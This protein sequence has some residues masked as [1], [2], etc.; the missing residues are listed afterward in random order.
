VIKYIRKLLFKEDSIIEKREEI[1]AL[2]AQLEALKIAFAPVIFQV[3]RTM[4]EFGI[5]TLLD[6]RK[7]GLSLKEI[8][9]KTEISTYGAKILL[10]SALSASVVK[11]EEGKYT[12]TKIGYFLENDAMVE[13]NM[14]FNHDVNYKGLFDLDKSIK[15]ERPVGLQVFGDW[16]TIYPHLGILPEQVKKSWFDFDHFYSD[17]AFDSAIEKLKSFNPKK[18]LDIGGNTGKFSIRFAKKHKDINLTILDLPGQ[19]NMAQKNIRDNGLENNVDYFPLDIL[20]HTAKIP[21]GFDIIW[22]S[23]FIDC[24]S[25]EDA[26]KILTRVRESMNENARLCILEPLWD[27]QRFESASYCIINTS[28]YFTAMANGNS[29][30]FNSTDLFDYIQRAG[31]EIEETIANIG[32][33]S[34]TL[35]KCKNPLA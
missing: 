35:V 15:E 14:A 7:E 24:F 16:E 23:Q 13:V 20:N 22:M 32:V 2:D 12:L 33:S 1:S 29:K 18:V 28:P 8:A 10:E 21:K 30:M 5:L 4:K 11:E 34:H 6:K 26:I 31:L 17:S 3:V 27:N 25:E 19:I 9:E